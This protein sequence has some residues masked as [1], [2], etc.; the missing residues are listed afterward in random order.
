MAQKLLL[1]IAFEFG[2][3]TFSGGGLP[4]RAVT[5]VVENTV[6]QHLWRHSMPSGASE[7]RG[8]GCELEPAL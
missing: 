6:R 7:T 2:Q 5:Y 8:I 3:T 4:Q 1:T